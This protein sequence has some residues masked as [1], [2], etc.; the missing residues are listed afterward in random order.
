[1]FIRRLTRYAIT[2]FLKAF[3]L[4][5]GAMTLFMIV[6]IVAREA[7]SNGLGLS[8]LLRLIP[9]V[10]PEA[11]LFAVPATTLLAVCA[12]FGRLSADNEL[13]AIKSAG[14]SPAVLIAPTLIM[15]FLISLCAVWLNDVAVSWGEPGWRR[16]IIESADQI[17][18]RMLRAR[19]SYSHDRFSIHVAGVEGRNLVRPTLV[20]AGRGGAPETVLT[21]REAELVRNPETNALSIRLTDGKVERG[22]I[23]FVFDG[24]DESVVPLLDESDHRQRS[25]R[26]SH[27]PFRVIPQEIKTQRGVVTE[28]RQALATLA[29]YQMLTGRLDDLLAPSWRNHQYL[30]TRDQQRLKNLQAVPWRRWANGFSCLFFAMVGVPLAMRMRNSNLFTTFAACFFPILLVYYPLLIYGTERAKLGVL[31]PYATWLGNSVCCVVG[32]ILLRRELRS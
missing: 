29:A 17:A 5:L 32:V 10:L 13:L 14:I 26:P 21:A 18:Y 15:T 12:V 23:E 24:Q 19:K 2:E 4:T 7:M 6:V 27:L 16:V 30:M 1:M 9:Y 22:D 25:T 31:P 8:P 11:L 20:F 28:H 3:L